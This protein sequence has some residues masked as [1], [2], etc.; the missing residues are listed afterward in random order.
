[1][2]VRERSVV[3]RLPSG[4]VRCEV[5]YDFRPAEHNDPLLLVWNMRPDPKAKPPPPREEAK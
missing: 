3:A 4:Q 1:M 5:F 2:L